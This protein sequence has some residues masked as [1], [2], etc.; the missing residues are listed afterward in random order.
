[1]VHGKVQMELKAQI[2]KREQKGFKM[3]TFWHSS[4]FLEWIS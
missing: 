1:M 4:E 3:E 2:K